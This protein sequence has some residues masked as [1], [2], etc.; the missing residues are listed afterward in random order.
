MS[1]QKHLIV[2]VLCLLFISGCGSFDESSYGLVPSPT[3]NLKSGI[4][5]Q[6]MDLSVRPQDDFY[7]YANGRWLESTTIP[8][9]LSGYDVFVMLQERIIEQLKTIVEE[10]ANS[11]SQTPDQ[12]KI[13][14]LYK[15]FM[16]EALAEELSF[17]P[18][19]EDLDYLASLSSISDIGP[20]FARLERLGVKCPLGI[21][22]SADPKEPTVKVFWLGQAGL[23]L[24]N[25][26]Y[27]LLDE[28]Q[29]VALRNDFKS[30]IADLLAL[31][32]Y[33]N[34][35]QAAERILALEVEIAA[36]EMSEV[37]SSD[38]ELNYNPRTKE[39]V[40]ELLGDLDWDSYA[41]GVG[42]Q[43]VQKIVVQNLSYFEKLEELVK[44]TDIATWRDYLSF[45][46]LDDYAPFL[47][48]EF[49]DLHFE[50]YGTRL[51]GISESQ[52]RWRRAIDQV[53]SHLGEVLGKRY[54]E[55]HFDLQT[56]ERVEKMVS[57]LV[58]A[59]S[60]SISQISWMSD[61][62][63]NKALEKLRLIKTKI[64]Y[65]DKWEDYSSL[66]IV[67]DDLVGNIKRSKLFVL[68]Q[69]L[70]ELGK[71]IDPSRWQLTPQ[72]INAY[73]NRTSNEIVFAA[74]I[75]QP[76]FFNPE[77]EDAVNYGSI[78]AVIG[79]EIGHGFDDQGAKYDGEG[80]LRNWWTP[81]DLSAFTKLGDRLAAQYDTY[82][83]LQ[84]LHI[85]GRL[86]LGENIGD[87]AGLTMAS[88]AY[89]ISLRGRQSPILDGF[90][91][92]QRIFLGWAQA[93][94]SKMREDALRNLLLTDPHSPSEYRVFGPLRQ[95]EAFY[96]AFEVKEG[97]KM[98][99]DPSEQVKIW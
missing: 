5:L 22:V 7:R 51:Q 9:N 25:R 26:D 3:Q 68:E 42:C 65:P 53:E 55:K 19:Q 72:T 8:A 93:M 13:G 76:P 75:L 74:A 40:Q 82:F 92:Q 63:K 60:E 78:G 66:N 47:S 28:A 24:P 52:P 43:G 61:G 15:S 1:L 2:L 38:S 69:A 14:D 99:L 95:I 16:N 33:P 81:A 46:L 10:C 49:I 12:Q 80:Y 30:Y 97:D 70:S 85:N 4:I 45:H 37:E 11:D 91:G 62:T 29:I 18:I 17:K 48:K 23:S 54:V 41:Q 89:T 79:H 27:Y 44:N 20:A 96:K 64:G 34:P 58:A 77:A 98:Y 86:T 88:R 6:A 56:K 32:N 35:Q 71:P 87:L 31:I 57:N 73:Y 84:D 94:R 21:A 90:S 39:Q 83:P 50:F 59:Y 67:A 36:I